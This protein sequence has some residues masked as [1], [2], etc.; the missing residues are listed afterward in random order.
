MKILA[1]DQSSQT[2]GYALFEG[3]NLI[4]SGIFTIS[5]NDT[6]KRIVKI[7]RKIQKMIEEYQPDKVIIEDIQW[8]EDQHGNV[9][10]FKVLAQLQGALITLFED[11]KMP[12]DIVLAGTWRSTLKIRGKVRST[13]K[14]NAQKYVLEEYGKKVSEDEADAICI[15]A[16]AYLSVQKNPHDWA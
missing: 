16:H 12:Y 2:S 15:G 3:C 1:F 9:H 7:R 4:D 14:A 8:E 10:T 6:N 5:G 11:I 13:Y